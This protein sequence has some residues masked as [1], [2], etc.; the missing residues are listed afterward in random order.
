MFTNAEHGHGGCMSK[1]AVSKL[2][3]LMVADPDR[4]DTT[5]KNFTLEEFTK[6]GQANGLN[7]N[8]D[9]ATEVIMNL[10]NLTKTYL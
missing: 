6:L 2:L 3:D 4:F 9:E 10:P 7:F 1:D 5:K 8:E